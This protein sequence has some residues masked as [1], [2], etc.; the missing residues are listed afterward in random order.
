MDKGTNLLAFLKATAIMRRPRVSSYGPADKILWLADVPKDRAECR[1]PFLTDKPDDLGGFWLEVRKKRMPARPPV[2]QVVEDWV[3]ADDLDQPENEPEL[4]PEITV[5]VKR[6]VPDPDATQ[7]TQKTIVEEVREQRRLADHPEVEEAWIEYL[8]EKW[9]P[10]AQEMRRWQEVQSVYESL[11]FMRRRLD[12]AEERY[13]LVLAIGLLQWRDPTGT[14]VARH[15]LTAPAEITLDAARGL[16]TILPAA[17][18]DGFR[19]EFDMLEPQHR[20]RLHE[21]TLRRQLEVL[22][23]QAW[24]AAL[25]A[26]LLREIANS[27]SA[28]AQ[29]DE[30]IQRSDRV[31]EYPRLSFAPA[32]VLRERRSTAYE[33]LIRKF[34]EAATGNGLEGTPPW[35][36]L[37]REGELRSTGASTDGADDTPSLDETVRH[38]F[39]LPT[40][41]EQR[42]I[43]QWLESD[44]CVLVK[45]PPGTGKSHTIANLVCHLLAKGE[46][47]LVTAH[48]PKALAVLRDLFP[49]DIRDLCVTALGSSREDQRLL[50]ESVRGILRRKNEWRGQ[51]DAQSAIEKAEGD[52]RE[53]QG[54]L[55]RVERDLR[56]FREAETHS[57]ELPGGYS[58]TAA[59]IARRLSEQEQE[60]GWLP[61]VSHD[62]AF[63]LDP[64]ESAFLTEAHASF[65]AAARAELELDIGEGELPGPDKFHALVARLTAAEESAQRASRGVDGAKLEFLEPA[66]TEQLRGLRQAVQAL[67]DLVLRVG[68]VLGKVSETILQ[69]LLASAEARWTRRADE[70]EALLADARDLLEA[71]G[72]ARVELADGIAEDRLRTD[73][74]RRLV[75]FEAGGRK[76]FSIFAPRVVRE[77][78]YIVEGC[79]VD[80]KRV[81]H[82]E[83]LRCVR[84]HLALRSK[85]RELQDLWGAPL[86]EVSSP[87]Q[88]VSRAEELT[89]ELKELLAFFK[90]D[91]AGSLAAVLGPNRQ[92]LAS[93]SDRTDWLKAINALLASR[94][95]R[96][97]QQELDRLLQT[98]RGLQQGSD[99]HPCLRSLEDAARARDVAAWRTAWQERE[100]VRQEKQRLAHYDGL[101]KKLD[102]S[103]PGLA[104]LLR[105]TG[106][107]PN[108][109]DRICKLREAWAWAAA[110]AWLR[111]VTDASA[112]E[113]RVQDY[114]R[115]RQKIEKATE[116]LVSIRAWKAFFDRLDI[117]TIQSLNAWTR[118]VDRIG[119]GTG[120]HAYR[121]RRTARQYLM[122]CVPRIPAW[123]M[124]LHK[125]WDSVDAVPGLFDTVIVDEA[126]QAGVDALVLLL[127]AKRI[128]VV[129]DDKQ[130]SPE[131][132]GVPEDDIARLA[133]EHLSAFRFRDEF[134]PD[135]SLFDHSE[136]TFG[137]HITLRE[138]FRCVPEIIRFSN[139]LCYRDAPLIPLRQAPPERLPPLRSRFVAEGACE[140]TGQR[141][142]NR[143]EAEALVETI[144]KLVDDQAYEG[145]TMGVIAL[146]G[147]A[148][149][150]LIETLLAQKLDPRA[151]EERRLR[152]GEPATFQGDQRDVIFLSL[153]I[154]P[155]VHYRAL[156]RLPDHR[157]FNVAMSR[158][159]DQVWLFH[160]VRPHDLGA[161]DLRRRLVSFFESP[162][163]AAI[164]ALFEDLDRL[165][166]EARR[167]RRRGTQPSPY[168]SWFEVDVALELMRRK[169][170]IRPQ[171]DVASYRIDIVVEGLDARLAVECDGDEW[172]GTERYEHDMARQR[173]LE[174]AGWTFVRV[175]ASDFYADRQRAIN[176]VVEACEELGIPPVDSVDEPQREP[177]RAPA[178]DHG[179]PTSVTAETAIAGEDQEE[180]TDETEGSSSTVGPFAGY[181]KALRFPDPRE[182]SP[183]N[184]RE[185][186]RQIIERD[187]PLTRSSVYRLYVE[188]C[189]DL[190]RVG[191]IVRQALNRAL[192]TMLRAGEIVQ[193][194]ELGD[195]SPDSQVLRIAGAP[196]VKVRPAG[197]RD[198]LDIPPS[199]LL[200]VLRRSPSAGATLVDDSEALSR[201]LLAHYGFSRLTRSRREYLSKV[202]RV[203]HQPDYVCRGQETDEAV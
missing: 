164:D 85:L 141:I 167:P 193:E 110:R 126:S 111:R 199:E 46:R 79:R 90:S 88:A 175:R 35:L 125:L 163:N 98:V 97:A 120:K 20:P 93:A 86:T 87:R 169:F 51:A 176:A 29:V 107:E 41:E 12:E 58:G 89:A 171:V 53:L 27:L 109:R 127:L 143:A 129:G 188:G 82:V 106:N 146:Q 36:R 172:H 11:D 77:T 134:R 38:L 161:D 187:G 3:R 178:L 112:Y 65:T 114:H 24:D 44:P 140:G 6:Q 135:T 75:H 47:I 196:A 78:R 118:A 21:E 139:D 150:Q 198:L 59:Q 18:F 28:D 91:Q 101:L 177:P 138:H 186:L 94:E 64:S 22:D 145:K 157:R 200:A 84:D 189:P 113:A 168:E 80:A 8:V 60:F 147:H 68:R 158:A 182:A 165:E 55:A 92:A 83:Q 104:E 130:N 49:N 170:R 184:V 37:V 132:V 54:E 17:S 2:P 1:S 96:D 5:I 183:A 48:A 148:Q 52:L 197:R 124:P 119:K 180:D 142:Q 190:Q 19:V 117:R 14:A 7:D 15:V 4:L 62:A 131:A 16:L 154:A 81:T 74:E 174:R 194:D 203:F 195:G 95:A 50:E 155:N 31:E 9:E 26:P 160:S 122:D 33:D 173:Q 116:R 185:I 63:P 43:V 166:R 71:I 69:D 67:T 45:G 30:T 156:T 103:S 136:R 144:V 162:Q 151:I 191:K 201:T 128:I 105:S 66:G 72:S 39:P 149:A 202:L 115:L 133:R 179:T 13:E 121:H 76:G 56:A 137:R 153:V 57:H 40:N 181:S 34:L 123:V 73:V 42:Q 70:S 152:C 108:W 32:I 159:R 10:W 99:A 23:I 192:G 61:P 100:R 25:V 102:A